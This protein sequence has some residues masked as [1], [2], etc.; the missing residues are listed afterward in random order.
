MN[1]V[2]KKLSAS[3]CERFWNCPG[4]VS[5]SEQMPP[6]APN[7]YAA[8]GTY[9]H[10]M[11][12]LEL[13]IALG[14]DEKGDSRKWALSHEN[15]E[16]EGFK[17]S[18]DEEMKRAIREYVGY[19]CDLRDR[20]KIGNDCIQTE[21]KL[22]IPGN[23]D[24]GGTADCII[25]VPYRRIVAIDFKYGAGTKVEV[26]G[27]KQ[28]QCYALGA[29]YSLEES[30][31]LEIDTIQCIIFQPRINDGIQSYEI[32]IDRLHEFHQQL[33]DKAKL[34]EVAN[35]EFKAG[36]WCK[37]CPAQ[38]VCKTNEE[39]ISEQTGIE[40][41]EVPLDNVG[42]YPAGPIKARTG[43]ELRASA[44]YVEATPE[45]LAQILD[46]APMIRKWLDSV[47]SYAQGEALRGTEIPGYELKEKRGNRKWTISDKD[48]L[49][50]CLF[51]ALPFSRPELLKPNEVKSPAEIE[52]Y[53][54]TLKCAI[55]LSKLTTREVTGTT[56]AKIETSLPGVKITDPFEEVPI[57]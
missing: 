43:F 17:F 20:Y 51:K 38:A 4:S 11:A 29:Y 57:E 52:K 47:A 18:Y 53:A 12:E 44:Y 42:S 7:K 1:G 5:L 10:M 3:V 36:D 14:Q 25:H 24:L 49:V 19:I 56:L 34:T 26:E 35:P 54:K 41:A 13:K 2:H 8:E 27:N 15:Y 31:Q 37:Y 39:Y 9:A 21:T 45:R 30:D 16:V 23:P 33:L 22:D 40:F 28:L 48:K 55:D 50:E 32:S 46:A 6:S